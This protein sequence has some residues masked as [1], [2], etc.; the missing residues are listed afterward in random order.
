MGRSAQ[1]L[2]QILA[3]TS[4]DIGENHDV[5]FVFDLDSTLFD[6]SPR[7]QQILRD[8]SQLPEIRSM[9]PIN[10]EILANLTADP[11]DWGIRLAVERA[12][13]VAANPALALRVRDFWI[14]HFFSN[15]YL[16]F[17][18]PLAGAVK[19]VSF[20]HRIGAK[21]VY[22]TGRDT[23]KMLSGSLRALRAHDFPLSEDGIE[24]VM[25]PTTGLED[26]LFKETWF[27]ELSLPNTCK[28]WFFE[29]EPL[30]L[31]KVRLKHPEVELVFVDTTHSR[32][33]PSPTD[34]K[35]IDNFQLDWERLTPR[36][37][38]SH[39]LQIPRF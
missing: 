34:L 31:E 27:D 2:E 39:R 21:L 14:Q 24:L 30:N 28:I 33:M 26:S 13:I 25:K 4:Q 29:N 17:D 16:Q 35:T 38:D 20:V 7:I 12:G 15:D 22:L 36:L 23:Q 6:V 37:L 8:F 19:F 1:V 5:L 32:K 9:D 10:A 18:L 11:K 3:E